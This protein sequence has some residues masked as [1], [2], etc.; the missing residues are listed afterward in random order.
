MGGP[1]ARA[2]SR[3]AGGSRLGRTESAVPLIALVALFAA[4]VALQLT[5]LYGGND[6]V[7]RPP[8][9]TYAEYARR[10]SRS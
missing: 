1:R 9:L 10:A 5:T 7:L 8:A 4:F 6:Y 3:A 2:S